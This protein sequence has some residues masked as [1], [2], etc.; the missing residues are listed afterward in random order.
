M[1]GAKRM[2][3]DSLELQGKYRGTSVDQHLGFWQGRDR[4]ARLMVIE[5]I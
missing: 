2:I 5:T 3:K 4:L 1:V